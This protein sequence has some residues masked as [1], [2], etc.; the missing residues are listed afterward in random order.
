MVSLRFREKFNAAL[1]YLAVGEGDVRARLRLAYAQL[2]RLRAQEVP[3]QLREEWKAI[4]EALT[5]RGP[6]LG[7]LGHLHQDALEHTLRHMRNATGRKLAERIYSMIRNAEDL[8]PSKRK[9]S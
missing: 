1:Y 3:Q 7:P 2:R 9:H 6:Q 4:L 8:L 5:A